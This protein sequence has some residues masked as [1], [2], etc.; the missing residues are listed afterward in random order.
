M[1]QDYYPP[2]KPLK[3][4]YKKCNCKKYCGGSTD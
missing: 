3:A 2:K 1:D 4:K